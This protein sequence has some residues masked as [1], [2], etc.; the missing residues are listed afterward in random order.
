[1]TFGAQGQTLY[2]LECWFIDDLES[3]KILVLE[4]LVIG[5]DVSQQMIY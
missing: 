5:K 2:K 3:S 1:M 4:L